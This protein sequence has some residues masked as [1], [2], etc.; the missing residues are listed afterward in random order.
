MVPSRAPKIPL[1]RATALAKVSLSYHSPSSQLD[2]PK[3][4]EKTHNLAYSEGRVLKMS[5]ISDDK[6]APWV[7]GILVTI[8]KK[9][10]WA[11]HIM[12]KTDNR[13]TV[14]VTECRKRNCRSREGQRTRWRDEI[15]AFG[16]AG[17]GTH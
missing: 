12:R 8:V 10:A 11:G 9:C 17:E 14:K 16:G 4:D 15:R 2:R 6:N 7:E 3:L 5:T 13:W 1:E